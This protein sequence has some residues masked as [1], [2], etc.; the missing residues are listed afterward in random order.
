MPVYLAFSLRVLAAFWGFW[1]LLAF[2]PAL[3]WA[4]GPLDWLV[5]ALLATVLLLWNA[6]HPNVV[7]GLLGSKPL[8]DP[9]LADRFTQMA[10]ACQIAVP[11]FEHVDM[12]G[13]VVANAVALASLR[14][15]AVVFTDTLLHRLD[16][17][18]QFQHKSAVRLC[19]LDT[20]CA[21]PPS[22]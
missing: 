11:R 20:P 19:R 9:A 8:Q 6:R 2:A 10:A 15:S 14:G 4:A 7:R 17:V 18:V 3:A 16:A 12:R 13:G 5:A 1:I 21:R 22:C